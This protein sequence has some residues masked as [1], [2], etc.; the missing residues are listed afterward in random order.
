MSGNTAGKQNLHLDEA[1]I[2]TVKPQSAAPAALCALIYFAVDMRVTRTIWMPEVVLLAI[3][4]GMV[5]PYVYAWSA[6]W[7]LN[8]REEIYLAAGNCPY[9][10]DL[11]LSAGSSNP[12]TTQGQ[13]QG[14][15]E[16][17]EKAEK[18]GGPPESMA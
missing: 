2:L 10:F 8:S 7:T 12:D 18:P 13:H 3:I 9:T 15:L 5:L 6:M 11:G 4:I 16:S 1:E 17:L 14:N